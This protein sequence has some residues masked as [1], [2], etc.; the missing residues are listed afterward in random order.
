MTTL[1]II[2]WSIFAGGMIVGCYATAAWILR[3]PN[4]RRAD[5]A[6]QQV[7]DDLAHGDC[8][9]SPLIGQPIDAFRDRGA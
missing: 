1:I 8:F 9:P 7:N 4:S 2:L 6:W 3:K 5:E